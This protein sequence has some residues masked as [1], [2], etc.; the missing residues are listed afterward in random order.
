MDPYNN[1]IGEQITL[2]LATNDNNGLSCCIILTTATHDCHTS[3][4]FP[5]STQKG[6]PLVHCN[7]SDDDDHNDDDDDGN[8]DDDKE[9]MIS[10]PDISICSCIVMV[11]VIL[12]CLCSVYFPIFGCCFI[13]TYYLIFYRKTYVACGLSYS[14]CTLES[15]VF[16][17]EPK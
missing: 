17:Y 3:M 12:P 16:E 1:R 6:R 8:D 13:C 5:S 7:C 4:E 14:S 2:H 11:L 9:P 15:T 10:R